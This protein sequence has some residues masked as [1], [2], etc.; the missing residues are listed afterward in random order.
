MLD[1]PKTQGVNS[2]EEA[3]T[4]KMLLGDRGLAFAATNTA[5]RLQKSQAEPGR[6]TRP[7]GDLLEYFFIDVPPQRLTPLLHQDRQCLDIVKL[8]TQDQLHAI[9][10]RLQ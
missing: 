3:R 5:S 1:R 2:F 9:P 7:L 8:K 10:Q 6:S 4:L